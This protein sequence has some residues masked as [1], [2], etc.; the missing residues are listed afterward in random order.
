MIR[1]I[2]VGDVGPLRRIL[3]ET[4]EDNTFV[5]R[6]KN[7]HDLVKGDNIRMVIG[8]TSLLSEILID[9]PKLGPIDQRP[10][11]LRCPGPIV[12]ND[13]PS[14]SFFSAKQVIKAKKK[15]EKVNRKYTKMTCNKSKQRG[16]QHRPSNG[17]CRFRNYHR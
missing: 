1:V 3:E 2:V 16:P 5:L 9:P 7:L 15:E 11:W 6:L 14:S 8:T 12:T 4:D 13:D 10:D 17:S